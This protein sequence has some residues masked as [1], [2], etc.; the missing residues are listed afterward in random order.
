ML[1]TLAAVLLLSVPSVALAEDSPPPP[2]PSDAPT[3]APIVPAEQAAAPHARWCGAHGCGGSPAK[4]IV[5]TTVT[6]TV[7]TAVAIAIAA[8]VAKANSTPATTLVVR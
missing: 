8:G 2:P 7:L 1:R 5:A 3:Q 6:A 4:F